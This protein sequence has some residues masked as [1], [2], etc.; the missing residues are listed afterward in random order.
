MTLPG[1]EPRLRMNAVISVIEDRWEVVCDGPVQRGDVIHLIDTIAERMQAHPEIRKCLVDIREA[2]IALGIMG[3]YVIGEYAAR[4]W[5]G[6]RIALL[7]DPGQVKK[8]LEDTAY[9]RGLRIS[10]VDGRQDALAWLNK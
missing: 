1:Q 6:L 5:V 7:Q 4:K 8:L 2:E 3:E 9:N 10:M